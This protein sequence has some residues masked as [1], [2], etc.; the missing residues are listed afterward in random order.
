M[1]VCEK[2]QMELS[3]LM[4]GEADQEALVEALDHLM[5]CPDC[6]EFYCE[7]RGLQ[8]MAAVLSAEPRPA[9]APKRGAAIWRRGFWPVWAG[10]AAMVLITVGLWAGRMHSRQV[11]EPPPTDEPLIGLKLGEAEGEMNEERFTEMTVEL[12]RAGERYQQKMY[13]VLDQVGGGRY[14]PRNQP[15]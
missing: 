13:E 9:A 7:A 10:A 3:A 8:E 12:L 6:A 5:T 15:M 11:Y 4:D 14:D 2:H 1:S